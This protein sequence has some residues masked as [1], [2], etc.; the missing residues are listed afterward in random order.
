MM[1][2]KDIGVKCSIENVF[3]PNFL[4][5]KTY[6]FE[7]LPTPIYLKLQ[8]SQPDP[9][10]PD[11][12]CSLTRPDDTSNYIVG[13]YYLFCLGPYFGRS[14]VEPMT[15]YIKNSCLCCQTCFKARLFC[16]A[17]SGLYE[18]GV[19]KGISPRMM[20]FPA[21]FQRLVLLTVAK[22]SSRQR[23]VYETPKLRLGL[24]LLLLLVWPYR[25]G[26]KI[27]YEGVT[28]SFPHRA[29]VIEPGK[30]SP[31][32]PSEPKGGY[33]LSVNRFPLNVLIFDDRNSRTQ[34]PS[35]WMAQA[36]DAWAVRGALSDGPC[37]PLLILP[38]LPMLMDPLVAAL[39]GSNTLVT[40]VRIDWSRFILPVHYIQS[41]PHCTYT[42]LHI[43][44]GRRSSV[45][46]GLPF[47]GISVK[48]WKNLFLKIIT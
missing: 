20:W 4:R 46:F 13:K 17:L 27:Y 23:E 29:R 22:L 3:F 40:Q 45:L 28:L 16:W 24:W 10:R 26:P 35:R 37:S 7:L 9:T 11:P 19:F 47:F 32:P 15:F 8:K 34:Q 30:I 1:I 14:V 38:Y 31:T 25:G 2:A 36:A 43:D 44:F 6:K 5:S 33:F 42:A 48:E 21:I 41:A 18:H 12:N 39:N